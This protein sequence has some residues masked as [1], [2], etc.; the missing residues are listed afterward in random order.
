ML[1]PHAYFHAAAL[2][3][4]GDPAKLRGLKGR[5]PTWKAAWEAL[6]ARGDTPAPEAAWETLARARIAL[7][8]QDDAAFPPLLREIPNPPIGLY[9]RGTLPPHK[10]PSLAIVG[11]RRATR[12]GKELAHALARELAAHFSIAS[13][14]A[15]GVDAAA[16][17]GCLEGNGHT[18]AVLAGGV[19]APQPQTNA[20]LAMRIV[21]QGGALV[22]E[23]PPGSA[24]IPYRFLERNR[25]VSGMAR[26]VLLVEAPESSGALVTARCAL[27]QN[28]EVFILPGPV[29][30][31]NFRGS[32]T[33]IREGARLVRNAADIFE[34]LGLAPEEGT[35]SV[36][37]ALP[38]LASDEAA[39]AAALR[40][41]ATPLSVDSLVGI[42]ALTPSAVNRAVSFLL[43]KNVVQETEGGYLLRA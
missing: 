21:E 36:P 27:E 41:A 33:L 6:A 28:R 23:Y 32:H 42:T 14:L 25:I 38:L 17:A 12:T 43:V 3:L 13:G 4:E 11:T 19:D 29:T 2:A 20:A 10:H 5:Y 31:P 24:P 7:L 8:L 30:H 18:V 9:V 16:H 26:G 39:V 40:E 1:P 37:R 15:L 35:T 34:D 22:S